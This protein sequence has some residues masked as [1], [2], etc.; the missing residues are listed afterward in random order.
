MV[1][2]PLPAIYVVGSLNVDLVSYTSRIPNA[3]ETL[4]SESFTT[5]YGGKGANQAVATA[6]LASS[7]TPSEHSIVVKMVGAVGDDEFG[8]PLK[9]AMEAEGIDVVD[10]AVVKGQRTGVAVILV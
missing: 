2:A 4:T 1:Q 10:V 3:G 6:R 5:G 8:P 9:Q 7:S